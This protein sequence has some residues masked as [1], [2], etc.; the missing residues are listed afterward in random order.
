MKISVHQ[1]IWVT[2]G[3]ISL[4]IF[5]GFGHLFARHHQAIASNRPITKVSH[6]ATKVTTPVPE[7]VDWHKPSLSRAYPKLAKYDDINIQ[8]SI[9]KQRVYLKNHDQTLYTMLA[10]TGKHGSDTPKGHFEIQAERGQHFFNTQSGEGANYWVSFKD[11]GIYLFHSVPVDAN[12]QYI[13]KEAQ[14][15]GKVANS[16]G[17]I[18]LTIADAKWLYENISTHTPVVVS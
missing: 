6:S 1:L 16:H 13:V 17:C 5:T 2:I 15:L 11:H 10:S 4:T 7:T 8:V 9:K 14:Q 12:D 3:A 18:R